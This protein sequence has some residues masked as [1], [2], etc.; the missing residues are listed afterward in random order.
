MQQAVGEHG[1]ILGR[2]S[3]KRP[4]H[5]IVDARLAAPLEQAGRPWQ[6]VLCDTL[7]AI[8][9]ERSWKSAA[10]GSHFILRDGYRIFP[11]Q[12]MGVSL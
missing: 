11:S 8:F 9:E 2:I 12:R 4:E 1:E 10:G 6:T 3:I 7:I 5:V